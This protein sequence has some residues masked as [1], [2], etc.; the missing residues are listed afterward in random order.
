MSDPI[1]THIV[2]D[3][4]GGHRLILIKDQGRGQVDVLAGFE[5]ITCQEGDMFNPQD[6][7]GNADALIQGI[8]NKAWD[9]G[10][11]P[12]GFADVKNETDAIRAHR[13]DMRTI[14]FHKLG[15]K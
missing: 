7:V 10:F 5:W 15:I 12:A 6:G 9:A 11:R 13:D 1:R 8:V 3:W 14:A 4:Q 2:R